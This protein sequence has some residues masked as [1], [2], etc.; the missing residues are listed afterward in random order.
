VNLR[1]IPLSQSPEDAILPL[2]WTLE[3]WGDHIPGYSREDWVE[4]YANGRR[5]NSNSWD[6]DG[7]ELIFIGKDGEEVIGAISLVDFDDLEEFRHL[8]PWVAAF[9]VNPKLRGRGIGSQMLALLEGEAHAR[10]VTV[11][12]LW[13][14]DK[15]EFYQKRGYSLISNATL[16][17]LRFDVLKKDLKWHSHTAL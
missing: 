7:Q 8:T 12:H 10:G 14:E 2:Q 6:G 5:G 16:G 15:S 17:H 3:L 11:L 13:T 4:F 1:L 9:I